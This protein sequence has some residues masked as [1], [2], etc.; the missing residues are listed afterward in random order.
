MRGPP[1]TMTGTPPTSTTMGHVTN[2][3]DEGH[4]TH[5]VV[6]NDG[7]VTHIDDGPPMSSTMTTTTPGHVD[8]DEGQLP[9]S[10][11]T[12]TPAHVTH[13]NE[14]HGTHVDEGHV[15]RINDDDDDDP[16]PPFSPPVEYNVFK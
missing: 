3:D 13:V 12:T 7:Q 4:V 8:H 14:G 9:M 2:D 6:I 11:L 5:V 10:S 15:T 1:T 16:L